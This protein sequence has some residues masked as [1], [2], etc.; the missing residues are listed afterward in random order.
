MSKSICEHIEASL[1]QDLDGDFPRLIES[2]RAANHTMS[3]WQTIFPQFDAEEFK[4]E[5]RSYGFIHEWDIDL[6]TARYVDGRS[7]REIEKIHNYISK[8]TVHRRLSFI[9]SE[10]VKRGYIKE[11]E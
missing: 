9:H 2:E 6:L 5:M 1:P 4:N 10:L 3:I 8:T 11:R 7:V